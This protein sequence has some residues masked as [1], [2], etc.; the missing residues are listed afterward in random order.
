MANI[1]SGK[2]AKVFAGDRVKGF[3]NLLKFKDHIMVCEKNQEWGFMKLLFSNN[4]IFI[5]NN[6]FGLSSDKRYCIE[7]KLFPDPFKKIF[8]TSNEKVYQFKIPEKFEKITPKEKEQQFIIHKKTYDIVLFKWAK[9]S[10]GDWYICQSNYP[11]EVDIEE[12]GGNRNE[13]EFSSYV[14]DVV[15]PQKINEAG[16]FPVIASSFT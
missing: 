11:G 10:D 9:D 12:Y 5:A 6:I 7:R 8:H 1:D 2:I 16:F 4:S 3:N 15:T 14:G 13:F